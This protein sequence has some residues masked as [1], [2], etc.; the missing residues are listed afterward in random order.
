MKKEQY[1]MRGRLLRPLLVGRPA[2]FLAAGQI[3]CT[4]P[5][6]HVEYADSTCVCFKTWDC[7]YSL[8]MPPVPPAAGLFPAKLATCA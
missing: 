6:I 1:E 2:Y 4:L 3:H 8:S 5:V 7:R